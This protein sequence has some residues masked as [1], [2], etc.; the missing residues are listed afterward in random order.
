MGYFMDPGTGKT[1]VAL[2]LVDLWRAERVLV[3]C[4]SVCVDVWY[5]QIEEHAPTLAQ[6]VEF[7]VFGYDAFRGRRDRNKSKNWARRHEFAMEKWSPDV[8]ICDEGHRIKERGSRQSRMIRRV[9]RSVPHRLILTGT[10]IDGGYEDLWSLFDMLTPGLLPD[11]Y[12]DYSDRYLKKGGYMGRQIIGYR[13]VSKLMAKIAPH[14]F[15]VKL[16]EAVELPPVRHVRVPVTMS[17]R[18]ATAYAKLYKELE[19]ELDG[20]HVLA[21]NSLTKLLRL[22]Q[23][24]GGFLE[25]QLKDRFKIKALVDL[26]SDWEKPFVVFAKYLHEIDLISEELRA[27]KYRVGIISGRDKKFRTQARKDFQDGRLDVLVIQVESGIGITL[28]R[29]TEAIFYSMSYSYITYQQ[30]LHRTRRIGSS[31]LQ[32]AT[33]YYLVASITHSVDRAIMSAIKRKQNLSEYL[34]Q[35]GIQGSS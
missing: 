32:G 33:Y 27:K 29:A 23:I 6:S 34:T 10:P 35:V 28:T 18:M 5:E 26:V 31:K 30:N 19:I 17:K 8:I 11:R 15:S 3:I 22:H 7:R 16:D 13:N 24:C 25:E 14:T 9:S 1:L 20:Q 21:L 12:E 2:A 4:P